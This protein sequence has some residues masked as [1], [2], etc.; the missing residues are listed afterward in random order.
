[1]AYRTAAQAMNAIRGA[2]NRAAGAYFEEQI[3]A[4]CAEYRKLQYA[5]IDKTPEPTRQ[6]TKMD[7]K[8]QFRA[9]YEKKAQPDF[10]GTLMGGRSVVFEAK[11]TSTGKIKQEA[12]TQ[13][14]EESLDRHEGLGAVCFVLVAFGMN[15]IRRVPWSMWKQMKQELGRR[16]ITPED[17]QQFKIR[18]KNGIL[19]FLHRY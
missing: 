15:D 3:K 7:E 9:C 14:Q 4:A 5:D 1:M 18:Q 8:G 2:Q 10:K 19:D 12:V 13:Q 16:Y 6:L 11:F 17:W